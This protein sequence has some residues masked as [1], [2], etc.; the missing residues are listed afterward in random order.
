VRASERKGD[1][2]I[3]HLLT[4]AGSDS[5]GGAGIQADLK[6][7]SALGAYGMSAITAVTAQNTCGVR[8]VRELDPEIVKDQIDCL[9]QDIRVDA[10]KIGMVSSP[11]II[12]IIGDL[13]CHHQAPH[14]VVDP[15]M[16]SKSG[17]C[18]L[19][20]QAVRELVRVLFPLAEVVTPNLYEAGVIM[21][22]TVDTLEQMQR[23]ALRI[24]ALGAM[25]VVVKGGHLAGDPVDVVYSGGV[26]HCLAGNR[27]ATRNTHGTGCTFSSAIAVYLADDRPVFQAIEL[28]KEYI[29]GALEHSLEIGGG[30]GPTGHFY[31]L[32]RR[33]GIFLD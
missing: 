32:Y 1:D 18:L 5:C 33:A 6:T 4:I 3:K 17:C 27:M 31:D 16:V 10:V 2:G 7:F 23:A 20:P 30:A 9:F 11:E 25:N 26:F 24:A 15:V 28:A 22:E 8:S 21:G 14:I 19:Q 12:D 13:L 29:T